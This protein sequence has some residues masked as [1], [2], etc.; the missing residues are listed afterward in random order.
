MKVAIFGGTGFVGNYISNKLLLEQFKP[1]CLVRKGS[2]S[3]IL[4][5]CEII[6]GDIQNRNS[7][8]KTIEDTDAIIYNI[9]II[10]EF[11]KKGI[12]FEELHFDGLKNSI[13]IAQQINVKRFILMSANGVK[14]NGTE[15][16]KT[17]W[18]AEQLLKESNLNWTIFKPS[19]IFGDP[20]VDGQP[21][22]CIQLKKDMLSLPFPA[23]LFYQGLL[24]FNAG[25]FSM[26]PIHVENVA[27]FFVNA[28]KMKSTEQKTYNLGGPETITWKNIIH[29]IAL[30]SGKMT[31]KIPAPIGPIKM[32]ASIF[33]EFEWFP[34]TKD[35]LTMLIEGNCVNENYFDE[36][37]ITPKSFNQENLKYLA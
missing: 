2:E 14:S 35:Q 12:T 20:M 24:P 23:P 36:F 5:Q 22:F 9:G 19:L 21:E 26:S 18:R 33:D 29:N 16:Q 11:P 1:K 10:R 8:I 27:D 28:L 17:K 6:T 31:W 7:I 3:K 32:V 30:A 37:S 13:E 15:Y 25:N 34:V 4:D